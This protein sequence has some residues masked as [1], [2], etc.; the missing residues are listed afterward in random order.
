MLGKSQLK[1]HFKGKSQKTI[2]KLL[3]S[4]GIVKENRKIE[5]T[6]GYL[7]LDGED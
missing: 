6:N 2:D 7:V 3:S 1:L 4:S 5:P